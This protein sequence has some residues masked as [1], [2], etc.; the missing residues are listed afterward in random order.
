[1]LRVP[2]IEQPD[3]VTCGPA[4]LL[5]VLRC[6]G[7]ERD[8]AEIAARVR[9]TRDGGTLGVHLGAAALELG[10][11]ARIASYNHRVFDPTWRALGRDELVRKLK[12]SRR[13]ARRARVRESLGAYARFLELGGQVRF[14]ELTSDLLVDTVDRGRPL[15][16]GLSATHLYRQV[17]EIPETNVEDD[18]R[19]EPVG[20]F[21]VVS[22]Y[23]AGG[24][25]FAVTDPANDAPFGRGGRYRVDATRLLNSILLGVTTYDGVLVEVWPNGGEEAA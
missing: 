4:C 5:M 2:R 15:I 13:H 20:H 3:D 12:S 9:R 1:M 6:L 14:P 21:V 11:G 23:S 10:Y 24:A 22:G 19:G 25:R 7:D 8:F 16:T 18:I 17:R